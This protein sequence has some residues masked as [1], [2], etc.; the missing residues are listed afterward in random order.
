MLGGKKA[1]SSTADLK[2]TFSI[3]L[4]KDAGSSEVITSSNLKLGEMIYFTLKWSNMENDQ[5]QFFANECKIIDG[6]N[7]I[8]IISE[9]CLA[10][11]VETTRLVSALVF[12]ATSKFLFNER[13]FS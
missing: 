5:V 4:Y 2:P 12:Y 8:A 3:S 11:V 1:V 9:T 6:T 10:G 7:E 13:L